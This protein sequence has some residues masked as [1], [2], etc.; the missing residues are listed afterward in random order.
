M[1]HGHVRLFTS[2]ISISLTFGISHRP[3]WLNIIS[4]AHHLV[5][6]L[7]ITIVENMACILVPP[8]LH[9]RRCRSRYRRLSTI[10]L[11]I[12]LPSIAVHV[13]FNNSSISQA[14]SIQPNKEQLLPNPQHAHPIRP[15][16]PGRPNAR[17]QSHL[18]AHRGST[19]P[20]P[21]DPTRPGTPPQPKHSRWLQQSGG[22]HPLQIL[23]Q[24]SHHG[25]QHL[26][27]RRADR[28]CLRVE[29]PFGTGSQGW[30]LL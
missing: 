29:S 14:L 10:P 19:Q 1:L 28:R 17:E 9:R 12:T 30:R 22:R 26:L 15:Q 16:H 20:T 7:Q 2:A 11:H 5:R 6:R 18:R 24:P 27:H 3:H 8:L 23:P 13:P 21:F 4:L 25:A